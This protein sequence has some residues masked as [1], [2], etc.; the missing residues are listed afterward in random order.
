MNYIVHVLQNTIDSCTHS[1]TD[2]H[3]YVLERIL[4]NS[5]KYRTVTAITVTPFK[6]IQGHRFVYQ[7]KAHI[8]LINTNLPPILHRFRDIAL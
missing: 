4:P 2:R 3:G 6:V 5:V 7:S 8:R 1:A